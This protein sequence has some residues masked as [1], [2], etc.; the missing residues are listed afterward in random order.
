MNISKYI[1]ILLLKLSEKYKILLTEIITYKNYKKYKTI[2]LIIYRYDKN[3]NTKKYKE[4]ET[5]SYKDL[6]IKLKGDDI[7]G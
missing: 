6:L 1:N 3:G 7:I 2:K 5:N 4:I